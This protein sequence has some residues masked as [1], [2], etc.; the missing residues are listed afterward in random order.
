LYIGEKGLN[1]KIYC[2]GSGIGKPLKEYLEVIKNIVN[3][4]Y[5]IRY[6]EIPYTEK[7]VKYLCAEI[8]EMTK[9]KGGKPEISFEKGI[10]MIITPPPPPSFNKKNY[11][12]LRG[13]SFKKVA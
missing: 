7:S 3:P 10:K 5:N 2:L 6:G 4:E 11:N 12:Y 13:Y 8:S 9:D 1:G